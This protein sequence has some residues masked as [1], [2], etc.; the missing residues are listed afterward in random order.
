MRSNYYD[1]LSG[2]VSYEEAITATNL[3]KKQAEEEKK[4]RAK[5]VEIN[6]I[7]NKATIDLRT[8]TYDLNDK[9]STLTNRVN[10]LERTAADRSRIP[11]RP[12]RK[13]TIK[14]SA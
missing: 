10:E 13:L 1:F 14:V 3:A 5:Q 2:R 7:V 4:K 12:R 6:E 8:A 11:K 9:I